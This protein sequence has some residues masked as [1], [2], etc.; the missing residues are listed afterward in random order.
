M[1]TQNTFN[2]S[3]GPGRLIPS[4]KLGEAFGESALESYPKNNLFFSIAWRDRI[5]SL[6]LNT[7][8]YYVETFRNLSIAKLSQG[9]LADYEPW[10][11][12]ESQDLRASQG[13]RADWIVHRKLISEEKPAQATGIYTVPYSLAPYLDLREPINVKK[14]VLSHIRRTERKITREVGPI[15]LREST[16]QDKHEWFKHWSRFEEET[17][18][19]SS[20]RLELFRKWTLSDTLPE[21][22]RLLTLYAGHTPLACGLFYV[23]ENVF[24][25]YAPVMNQTPELRKYG[26]GKLFVDKLVEYAKANS[27]HYFDFLQG[28][29]EYKFHWNPKVRQLYQ[30]I[31]PV[32]LKGKIALLGFRAK[33]WVKL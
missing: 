18:R 33:K 5:S 13:I 23:W 29:H 30:C 21:W 10:P 8:P 19:F 15:T 14:E 11:K 22:M 4:K 1:E 2:V 27:C 16:E 12:E 24:Y 20:P 17:S 6:N 26:P 9:I 3:S 7:T 32:S 25:Y 31:I 28:E